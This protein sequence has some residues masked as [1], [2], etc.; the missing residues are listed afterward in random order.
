MKIIV[1]SRSGLETLTEHNF[2]KDN[3]AVISITNPHTL[4]V[5]I[6]SSPNL[7]DVLRLEFDDEEKTEVK[8]GVPRIAINANQG[9]MIAEFVKR[10]L[11]HVDLLIVQ[12][13]AGMSRSAGVAAAISLVKN[14]SDEEFFNN[15]KYFPNMKC[16][17]TVLES[18]GY[19]NIPEGLID[20]K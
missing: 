18:F 6:K 4:S 10:M 13:E 3:F 7:W 14:G 16:Y 5:N 15:D 8:F 2:I 19:S 1:T 11:K 9:Y 12:C 17:R 20:R